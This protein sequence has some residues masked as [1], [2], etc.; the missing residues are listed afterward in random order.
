MVAVG[1]PDVNN[2]IGAVWIFTSDSH[3]T[4]SQAGS[5]L[6]GTGYTSNAPQGK[7]QLERTIVMMLWKFFLTF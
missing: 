6:V 1:G 2:R 4:Y 7:Q 3:D 5:K